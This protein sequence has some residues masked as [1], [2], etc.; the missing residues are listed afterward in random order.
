MLP[1][2]IAMSRRFCEALLICLSLLL[3]TGGVWDGTLRAGPLPPLGV[4]DFRTLIDPK[5]A[6][7]PE[8]ATAGQTLA[9]YRRRIRK[10]A[11]D[12][13]SLGEVSR[14]LLM[15]EWSSAEFDFETTVPPEQVKKAVLQEK[16]DAFKKDVQKLM[17]DHADDPISVDR[18]IVAEI[19]RS[20]RVYLLERLENRTRI[21]LGQGRTADRIAAA[22]LVSDTMNTSRRQDI[23]Q[24]HDPTGAIVPGVMVSTG[25]DIT[26]SSRYLR[27][28]M[29]AL[30][31]DLEKMVS[32]P[33]SQVRVAA[34]RALSDLEKDPA[35]LVRLLRPMLASQESDAP[36]RR[37]A[38]VALGHMLEVYTAQMDKSRPQPYLKA[39]EQ[40]LPAA[41]DGLADS[42]ALVRRGS[43]EACQQAAM[44]LE[45]LGREPLALTERYVVFQPTLAVV[46]KTL[47]KINACAGDR[48]PELRVGA[49][50]VLE[51]FALTVQRLILYRGEAL[52]ASPPEPSTPSPLPSTEPNDKKKTPPPSSRSPRENAPVVMLDRP[53]RLPDEPAVRTQEAKVSRSGGAQT[54]V[55]TSAFVAQQPD[56]LPPPIVI[57]QNDPGIRGTIQAMVENLKHPD[58]RVRLAAVDT[59]ETFSTQSAPAIPAL[60]EALRDYNKFVRWSAAR[61]L[62][63]LHPRRADEV[64]PGLMRMLDDRED[65]SVRI[66]ALQALELYGEHAKKAVP[67]LARV[68]NRGDKEYILAH[69]KTIQGIGTEA[70]PALPNVAW[71]LSDRSQPPSV[72]IEAANT[73]GRFGPLA[74]DQLSVLREIMTGD[75]DEDVRNAASTAVLSVDRPLTKEEKR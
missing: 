55:L 57:P 38:A 62:G 10:A 30:S 71:I 7:T 8:P 74:K 2:R 13:P 47:P 63:R 24:W 12:L 45:D 52:P 4:D 21:Y 23:S 49:S 6:P 65:P 61:T 35:E 19:K 18:A 20:V 16:D 72:R 67:L 17:A 14:V 40:V 53:I 56:E 68:I 75:P 11:E 37:A 44:T 73:L 64:V 70:A 36:T 39:I 60:V 51:T 32:D 3:L 29:R 48:V 25:R 15:S 22:N 59:L 66:A 31:G 1:I 26:P 28:R 46:R 27:Q 33:D 50:H 9:D 58:Y 43:L 5:R 54:L 41:A 34:I 69:L 42:D